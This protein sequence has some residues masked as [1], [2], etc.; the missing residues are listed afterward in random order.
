MQ[1]DVF[2]FL[3]LDTRF[4]ETPRRRN[5]WPKRAPTDSAGTLVELA[6]AAV[7]AAVIACTGID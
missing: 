6:G 3:V 5:G 2:D 4:A 1:A 7:A